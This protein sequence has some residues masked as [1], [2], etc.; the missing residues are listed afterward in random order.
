[1]LF[2]IN[3]I[4]SAWDHISGTVFAISNTPNKGKSS[5]EYSFITPTIIGEICSLGYQLRL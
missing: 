3:D 2:G 4:L 1:M 5:V